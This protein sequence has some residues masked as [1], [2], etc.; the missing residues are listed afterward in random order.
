MP[1]ATYKL[2]RRAILGRQQIVCTYQGYR[3]EICP[4][5]L[6]HKDGQEKALV[7]QFAGETGSSLPPGGEWRCLSLDQVSEVT[8][9]AGPWHS[10][11]HHSTRQRCVDLVELDVN[12]DVAA[13]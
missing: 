11:A 13:P 7:F 5:I 2:F 1:S 12:I 4:H 6:G 8:L 3:R 10:G 9:R